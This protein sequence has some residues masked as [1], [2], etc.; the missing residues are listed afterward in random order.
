MRNLAIIMFKDHK[1]KSAI[2]YTVCFF[3][4][5]MFSCVLALI[6]KVWKMFYFL[7]TGLNI[8]SCFTLH[9]PQIM[10][11]GVFFYISLTLIHRSLLRASKC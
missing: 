5:M 9:V 8:M 6:R 2:H 1:Q 7:L 3:I 11:F 10:Q 4:M